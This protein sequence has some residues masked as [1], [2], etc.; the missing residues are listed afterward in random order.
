MKFIVILDIIGTLILPSTLIYFGVML[1][2]AVT[3]ESLHCLSLHFQCL[4]NSSHLFFAWNSSRYLLSA[5]V[6]CESLL[7]GAWY[8]TI[9]QRN[10]QTNDLYLTFYWFFLLSLSQIWLVCQCSTWCCLCIHFG[11]WT[12]S[13]GAPRVKQLSHRLPLMIPMSKLL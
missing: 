8:S 6:Y 5:L 3:G 2:N 4:S 13:H 7:T 11:I 1:Y 10:N 12:T 9:T